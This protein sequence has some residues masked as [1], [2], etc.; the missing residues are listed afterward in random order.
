VEFSPRPC[1]AC[2]RSDIEKGGDLSEHTDYINPKLPKRHVSKKKESNLGALQGMADSVLIAIEGLPTWFGAEDLEDLCTRFG[3]VLSTKVV[4][5][6]T[7][8]RSLGLGFVRI[9]T[10]EAAQRLLNGL[11]EKAVSE[12]ILT[13]TIIKPKHELVHKD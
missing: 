9:A 7:T 8:N 4:R 6:M 13:I 2:L 10:I 1:A 12:H 5:D 3:A 11:H